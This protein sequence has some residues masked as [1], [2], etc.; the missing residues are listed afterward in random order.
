MDFN[1]GACFYILANYKAR[2]LGPGEAEEELRRY[3]EVEFL[4]H[5]VQGSGSIQPKHEV[6]GKCRG[7]TRK[8]KAAD[9][10][11]IWG[12]CRVCCGNVQK[13]VSSFFGGKLRLCDAHNSE[14]IGGSKGGK[15]T[16]KKSAAAAGVA[17]P[18]TPRKGTYTSQAKI[19]YTGHGA[20]ELLAGYGRHRTAYQRGGYPEVKKVLDSEI[21]RIWERNL[22]RDDRCISEGG[23]EGRYCY[24]EDGFVEW[25]GGL[26]AEERCDFEKGQGE[27]DKILL[28]RLAAEMGFK[29]CVGLVKRAMQFGS[30]IGKVVGGDNG[31]DKI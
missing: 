6:R 7:C 29:V 3:E 22:G 17:Q 2:V 19:V 9:A 16:P 21:G 26:K 5:N 13:R 14:K 12:G 11:C 25:V 15:G 8:V 1:L 4:R 27:G 18:Y 20:D 31:E 30:R 10:G 24:L 23:K 28:R